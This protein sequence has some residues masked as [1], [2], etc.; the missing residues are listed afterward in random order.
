M[1]EQTRSGDRAEPGPIVQVTMRTNNCCRRS[2]DIPEHWRSPEC[3][4]GF[5][6]DC[7][8][9]VTSSAGHCGTNTQKCRN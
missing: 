6:P 5:S 3:G 8:A 4:C 2:G 7:D 1:D 9:T